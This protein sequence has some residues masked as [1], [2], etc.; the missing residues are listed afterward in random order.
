MLF[1]PM[2]AAYLLFLLGGQIAA[3]KSALALVGRT[4]AAGLLGLGLAAIFWLPA[5]GERHDIK[6]EGIT[7]GFFD[8]RENFITVPQFLAAPCR[9]I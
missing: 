3:G 8:F 9:S 5:F 2:F 6:L 1:G 7:R 4:V